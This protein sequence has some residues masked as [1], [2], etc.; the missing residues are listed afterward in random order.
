VTTII[1]VEPNALLRLGILQLFQTLAAKVTCDGIDYTQLFS[2][3]TS[4]QPA[5]LMLLSTPDTYERTAELIQAGQKSHCPSRILLL[6]E[7]A[8]PAFALSHL[9]PNLAGYVS[10][11]AP[12]AMLT[13]AINLVLAGGTCFPNPDGHRTTPQDAAVHAAGPV[14]HRRWYDRAHGEP[15]T[16]PH[17]VIRPLDVGVPPPPAANTAPPPPLSKPQA[18]TQAMTQEL[19]TAESR[20][21]NLTAR[22]YEVLVLLARGYPIKNVSRELKISISTAKTHADTLY[23]RLSVH[24]SL[25]AVYEALMRGATLGLNQNPLS[26]MASGDAPAAGGIDSQRP[27]A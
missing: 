10:K 21:L 5:D 16:E 9:A 22:Q 13:A 17:D 1:V 14:P 7:P 19:V 2:R 15:R 27:A 4:A 24:N 12:T 20:L 6:S 11:H 8:H 23:Q 3:E 26:A 25:A 18:T